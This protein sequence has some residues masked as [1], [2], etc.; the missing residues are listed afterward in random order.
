ML[1]LNLALKYKDTNDYYWPDL[2]SRENRYVTD[3]E[4]GWA[5]PE[6][7]VSEAL[8]TRGPFGFGDAIRL[9][10]SKVNSFLYSDAECQLTIGSSILRF[11]EDHIFSVAE[12]SFAKAD[13]IGLF[14]L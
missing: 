14:L 1:F 2:E 8:G 7:R 3:D 12:K 4:T 6:G 13:F 10:K 11:N 9:D 5:S